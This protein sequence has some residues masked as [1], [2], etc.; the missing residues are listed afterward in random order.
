MSS[1]FSVA[2]MDGSTRSKEQGAKSKE[3]DKHGRLAT[4]NTANI[5]MS[6]ADI[7]ASGPKQTPEEAAAPQPPEIVPT[8]SASTSSLVDVDTPDIQTETQ[9]ARRDREEEQRRAEADLA[10]KKAAGK[11]RRADSFL[12]KWFGDMNDGASTALVISNLVGVVG[13]SG[14]LG[15]KAWDLHARNR[16]SWQSVGLGLGIMGVVG[17]VE[18][19]FGRYL[20]KGKKSQS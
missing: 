9:A 19:V 18:G 13:L 7:A 20:Y 15:Y 11:A 5:T 3:Q 10:K 16:L 8:E 17:A 4:P 14:F 12:T 6:Y 1:S 2:R